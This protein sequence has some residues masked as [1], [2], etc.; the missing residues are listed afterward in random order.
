MKRLYS[1]GI[2]FAVI[3]C[4]LFVFAGCDIGSG[5]LIDE[6]SFEYTLEEGSITFDKYTGSERNIIIPEKVNGTPIVR[7]RHSAF[8]GSTVKSVVVPST[9]TE[10]DAF[11][12]QDCRFLKKAVLKKGL[13]TLE[14]NAF[15]GCTLL[16]D[17][18]L[19]STLTE[20]GAGAFRGCSSLKEIVIPDSV[21][22]NCNST[23]QDCTSLEKATLSKQMTEIGNQMFH[24]CVKLSNIKL[25]EGIEEIHEQAFS[26]CA[27]LK[28]IT[29]PSTLRIIENNA[30]NGTDVD[31][32]II[33]ESVTEINNTC[34][35]GCPMKDGMK[36]E[37]DA[38]DNYIASG[39][40]SYPG[41]DEITE[42]K[43]RNYKKQYNWKIYYHADKSGWTAPEWNYQKTETW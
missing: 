34:F 32:V 13:K 37:G 31:S 6:S 4:S 8:A 42:E 41:E 39:T 5:K 11:A 10:I 43:I 17:I 36:F 27:S 18:K 9:V 35:Y 26:G 33:P 22:G 12:F 16:E 40:L 21:T 30:F 28:T 29:L 23:F 25:H 19:P 14:A 38:P 1:I 7:I 15:E 24:N 2:A 20:L 3:I